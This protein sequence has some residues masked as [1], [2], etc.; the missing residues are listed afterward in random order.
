MTTAFLDITTA[1]IARLETVPAVCDTILRA[2]DRRVP[3]NKAKAL[4]VYHAGSRPNEGAIAGA[5]IDWISGIVVECYAKSSTETPDA[6]VD[7]LI[8]DV[9]ARLAADITLGGL[10]DD[11]G[12]PTIQIDYDAQ[13][14]KTGW[15]V[16]K[17]PVEH[18]TD[19]NTLEPA[20]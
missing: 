10:V 8:Q 14:Q 5:P 3:E 20:P 19:N 9:Y 15:A 4:N 17:Y 18:R 16:L 2:N 13:G 7:Q 11:I 12:V 1:F 6:A